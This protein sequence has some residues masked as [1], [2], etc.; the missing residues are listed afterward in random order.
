VLVADGLGVDYLGVV[1]TRGFGRS[2]DPALGP[3]LVEGTRATKVAV[4]VDETAAAA[5]ALARAVGAGVIQLHG[6]ESAELLR[7]LRERGPWTLWKSVRARSFR[8][9]TPRSTTTSR[10]RSPRS[11]APVSS[12]CG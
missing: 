7:E 2:V 9:R 1:L 8:S 6:D 10:L 4:V 5:E 3:A 11:S 12:R